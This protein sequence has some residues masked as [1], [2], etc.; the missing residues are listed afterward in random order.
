M[1][2]RDKKGYVYIL[3]NKQNGTLYTGIT[4]DLLKRVYE[5]K[6]KVTKGFTSEYSVGKLGYFEIYKSITDAIEREKQLKSGSRN[7]KPILI[8]Q[9]NHEWRDLYD[10]LL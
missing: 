8:E 6:S 7:K 5:H 2:S 1:S 3:F 9:N 10:E 4:S